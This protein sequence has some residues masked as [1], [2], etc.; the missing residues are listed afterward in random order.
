MPEVYGKTRILVLDDEKLIRLTMSAKLKKIGYIPIAVGTVE[1]AVTILKTD[2]RLIRAVITDIVMGDMDGFVFRDIVRGVDP[3]MPIFFMTALDPEEGSGFLKRIVQDQMSY[4]LPK[5][6]STEVLLKRVQSIV[7]SRKV[8]QFIE[9]Q[10]AE[11]HHA[12]VLAAQIQRSM[13]P[14]RNIMTQR[15]FYTTWWR[16]KEA[17]SG[18]VY[19]CVP[20]GMGC[21]LYVLGDIQG[22][23]TSAALA[24]TAVQSF[25][26]NLM[27]REGAPMMGV[28]EIA[29][30]LQGFF[31]DNLADVS[32][33]TVLI[34]IHRPL[35]N[36]VEWIS[37]GAPDLV[38]IEPAE[39]ESKPINPEKR[40]G[41]PIGLLPDTVYTDAD[42]VKTTLSKTAVCIACTDG[43][44]DMAR[45]K[46]CL[47]TIPMDYARRIL[48]ELTR[49][50]RMNGSMMALPYK[51]M[52]ACE[53]SGYQ[54]YSDDVTGFVFGARLFLDGIYEAAIRLSPVAVDAAAQAMGEW[55]LNE[56]WS[57][58]LVDRVQLVIEE[59]LMNVYE[60]G[61]DDRE[62]LHETAAVRLRR[63][64]DHI[65]L[66]VWECGRLAPSMAVLGGNAAAAFEKKNREF[67][68]HGRGRLIVREICDG[69]ERNR[70]GSMNETVFLIPLGDV[71]YK[72]EKSQ[73]EG[74][75]V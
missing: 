72:G 38:V 18:D 43:L 64:K 14:V 29:N 60:H 3:M 56:G 74:F 16:P 45:D 63:M 4:Y 21:Y 50:A 9:R 19:E 7:A 36:L 11:T 69:I 75:F 73:E 46:E 58:D 12:R 39:K 22:H 47:E 68:N 33:M 23:G 5:A 28:D 53:Q 54:Y 15:G 32:Y 55:C 2:H 26:K 31:R 24:M 30:L 42:V 59:M 13:L 44:F 20:F 49:E 37:C 65:E 41:L 40:G 61:F 70:Y 48:D 62:R 71:L 8:E 57:H 67:D 52:E 27:H 10:M 34:C 51:F 1:E 6:I 17:V 35:E 25:L 66:T